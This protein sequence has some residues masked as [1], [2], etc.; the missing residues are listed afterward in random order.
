M[1]N[2]NELRNELAD[3]FAKLKKGEINVDAAEAMTNLSGKL[4]NSARAQVDYYALRGESPTID[5]LKD[6]TPI[7]NTKS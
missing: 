3:V 1:K 5:F 7:E 6:D 2:V 4:I